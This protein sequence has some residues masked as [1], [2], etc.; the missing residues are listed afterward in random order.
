MQRKSALIFIG[1]LGAFLLC[2]AQTKLLDSLNLSLQSNPEDTTRFNILE[3][4]IKA[5]RVDFSDSAILKGNEALQ[6]AQKLKDKKREARALTLL[7]TA[8][9]YNVDYVRAENIHRQSVALCLTEKIDS[10]L[11][12]ALGSLALTLQTQQKFQEAFETYYEALKMEEANNNAQGVVKTRTNLAIL[13]RN[14]GD[15]DNALKNATTAY[16]TLSLPQND[17]PR[18]EAMEASITN[19]IGLS[20]L[21]MQQYDS[22]LFYLAETFRLNRKTNNITYTANAASNIAYCYIKQNKVDSASVYIDKAYALFSKISNEG[23]KSAILINYGAVQFMK[24]HLTEALKF[25]QQGVALAKKVNS[26][27]WILYGYR[28]QAEILQKIGQYKQAYEFSNRAYLL[29]DSLQIMEAQR[30]AVNIQRD[31]EIQKKQQSIDVLAQQAKSNEEKFQSEIRVKFYLIASIILLIITGGATYYALRQKL[32]TNKKLQVKNEEIAK[33]NEVLESVNRNLQ[34]HALRIQMKPHFIFNALNS[35]Q[36]LILQ[37]ENE[38]AF[39]YLSKFSQLL[40]S[41]LEFSDQDFIE[42][43]KEVKWLELYIQ[44][45]ALRFN[46]GFEFTLDNQLSA[47]RQSKVKI[48]PL[49][50]QPFLENAIA[51]GLMTKPANRTLRLSLNMQAD[52][53]VIT[54]A[55][56]GIGREAAALINAQNKKNHRSFG[57]DL[58]S[59]RLEILKTITGKNFTCNTSDGQNENGKSE[60]TVVKIQIPI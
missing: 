50:I 27:N 15:F 55:D 19:T 3:A 21:D 38:K 4:Y 58:V 39:D 56:N 44:V 32:N 11:A 40:R 36:F 17:W 18:K 24:N 28:T 26:K 16:K 30:K 9:Y 7:G 23:I 8:H 46:H 49:L 2:H 25:T 6:L 59:K 43:D 60:G 33:K 13:Y 57:M 29:N 10:E 48:P 37:K 1:L 47:D 12:N 41:A 5:A 51:H 42:L 53:L 34:D 45:E 20:H 22:A 31:Y 35:I 52:Q 14:L 54:V